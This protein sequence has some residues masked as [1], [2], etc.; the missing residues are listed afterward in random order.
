[1]T[2][3]AAELASLRRETDAVVEKRA[4]E[5]VKVRAALRKLAASV[6]TIIPWV[7][8]QDST[9]QARA[10]ELLA[11][12]EKVEEERAKFDNGFLSLTNKINGLLDVLEIEPGK[13]IIEEIHELH[14]KRCSLHDKQT[15]G[16]NGL[17]KI[18][19]IG[20]IPPDS[21]YDNRGCYS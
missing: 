20:R 19:D 11:A 9:L 2:D 21:R 12:R 7:V 3:H 18:G 17:I 14:K 8:T 1:M 10:L 15:E 4:E 5:I 6:A 16:W 13:N